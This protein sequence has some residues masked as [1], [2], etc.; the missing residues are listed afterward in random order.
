MLV[1]ADT[2]LLAGVLAHLAVR[3]AAGTRLPVGRR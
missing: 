2:A 1:L 3:R